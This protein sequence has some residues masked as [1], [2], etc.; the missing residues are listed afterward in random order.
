MKNFL[1]TLL[2]ITLVFLLAGCGTQS[3]SGYAMPQQIND[4]VLTLLPP[5]FEEQIERVNNCDG[6]SPN[7]VVSC[8]YSGIAE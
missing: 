6:A 1:N 7:Y 5:T 3:S 4:P 2:I 8:N